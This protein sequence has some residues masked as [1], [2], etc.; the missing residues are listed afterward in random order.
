MGL[1]PKRAILVRFVP[2]ALLAFSLVASAALAGEPRYP[3]L[4]NF[5]VVNE[6]LYR[7]AQPRQGGLQRLG[8]LGV[9]TIINLR[10]EDDQTR[11]EETEAKS[12]GLSYFSI[13]MPGLSRPTVEQIS[14]VMEIIDDPAN[15]PVFVHCKRG[16]DR[17]GTV[18]AVYRISHEGWSHGKAILEAR[19][20]GLS[21]IQF[22]MKDYISDYARDLNVS[23][24]TGSLAD[25]ATVK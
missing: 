25:Q 22:G 1:R 6:K 13:P 2:A 16:S 23:S 8:Q 11:A 3:E 4:P 20:F 19:R 7:G 9:K 21:W 17:T 24:Q 10:G 14:K 12:L 15:A 18:I 5:H